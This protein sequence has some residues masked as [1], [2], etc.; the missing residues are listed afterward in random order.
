MQTFPELIPPPPIVRQR[1]ADH[2]REGRLLRALL[3][4]SIQAAEERHRKATAS[5]SFLTAVRQE[6]RP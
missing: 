5:E 3:K 2:I 4:V 6:A 1:L